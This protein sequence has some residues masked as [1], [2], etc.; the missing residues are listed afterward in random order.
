MLDKKTLPRVLRRL[1]AQHF[2]Q[3][4]APARGTRAAL[5]AAEMGTLKALPSRPPVSVVSVPIS[6]NRAELDDA[7]RGRRAQRYVWELAAAAA[8]AWVPVSDH[9]VKYLV[10]PLLKAGMLEWQEKPKAFRVT[11]KTPQELAIER[12]RFGAWQQRQKRYAKEQEIFRRLDR[13]AYV[14]SALR[15]AWQYDALYRDLLAQRV[16]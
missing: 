8:G 16:L 13:T 2:L 5:Y 10:R 11:A 12:D 7:F 1:I 4:V 14:S 3:C 15:K 9:R 6:A